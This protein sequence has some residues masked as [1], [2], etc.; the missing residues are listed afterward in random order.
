ME[1]LTSHNLLTN[2][3]RQGHKK[4]HNISRNNIL[5]NKLPPLQ[6]ICTDHKLYSVATSWTVFVGPCHQGM[7]RPQ[8][9]DGGTTSDMEGSC[10]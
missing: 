7:G 8:V 1:I 4:D 6:Y 9:A 10:E 5:V 3:R 2:F